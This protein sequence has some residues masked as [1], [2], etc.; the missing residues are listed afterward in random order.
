MATARSGFCGRWSQRCNMGKKK[1]DKDQNSWNSVVGEI[2]K[3]T[4]GFFN[5]RT[6][7]KKARNVAVTE[8]R[9][10]D[11]A[12]A[13]TKISSKQGKEDKM[14]QTYIPDLTLKPE[15]HSA[16]EEDSIVSRKMIVGVTRTNEKGEKIK[17]AIFPD[18]LQKTGDR[19]TSEELQKIRDEL[20]NDDPKHREYRES[21]LK[22]WLKHFKE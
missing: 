10:D 21:L 11:G 20:H 8:Q 2:L 15:E 9:S 14:G 22:R 13:I 12:I 7:I 18:D 17:R 3:T 6:D 1:D 5:G 4:D 19:L 16:L